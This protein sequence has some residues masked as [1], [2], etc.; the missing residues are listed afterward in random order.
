MKHVNFDYQCLMLLKTVRYSNWNAF[1][2]SGAIALLVYRV[3]KLS[4]LGPGSAVAEWWSWLVI[5]YR[6]IDRKWANCYQ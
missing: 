3:R 5:T 4:S 6:I 1:Q 2:I